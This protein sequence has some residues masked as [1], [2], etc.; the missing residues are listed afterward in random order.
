MSF[1]YNLT[2][3]FKSSILYS[4]PEITGNAE[5]IIPPPPD[6]PPVKTLPGKHGSFRAYISSTEIWER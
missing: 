6:E 4:M 1:D 2:N 5:P 3:F